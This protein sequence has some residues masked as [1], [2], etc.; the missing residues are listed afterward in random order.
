[1]ELDSQEGAIITWE[2]GLV[3]FAHVLWVVREEHDTSHARA[4]V[5]QWD[6]FTQ[7]PPVLGLN[8]SPTVTRHWRNARFFFVYRRWT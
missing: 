1:M 8:S 6:F 2:E 7:A 3:A 4:D 5:V